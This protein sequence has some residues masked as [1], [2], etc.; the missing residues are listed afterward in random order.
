MKHEEMLVIL[1]VILTLLSFILPLQCTVGL[2]IVV[3]LLCVWIFNDSQKQNEEEES[4]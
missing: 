2:F 4:R 1:S 3:G